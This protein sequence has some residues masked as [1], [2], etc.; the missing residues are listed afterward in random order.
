MAVIFGQ[1]Q[2]ERLGSRYAYRVNSDNMSGDQSEWNCS[3]QKTLVKIGNR[4]LHKKR[5]D[6]QSSL[7]TTEGASSRT[8][9]RIASG[10]L[11]N[12]KPV[13]GIE[14]IALTW[15]FEIASVW[16][17]CQHDSDLRLRG[18]CV[19]PFLQWPRCQ[20]LQG[21]DGIADSRPV[22]LRRIYSSFSFITMLSLSLT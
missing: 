6:S 22:S 5:M 11:K 9:R 8:V 17:T 10:T 21:T 7:L 12:A 13:L 14:L 18:I 4:Q 3:Q 16:C 2:L 20:N 19:P 1:L 15:M